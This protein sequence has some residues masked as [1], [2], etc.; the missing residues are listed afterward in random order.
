MNFLLTHYIHPI[1]DEVVISEHL[2]ITLD[3][4][5]TSE[6]IELI[7]TLIAKSYDIDSAWRIPPDSEQDIVTLTWIRKKFHEEFSK[8]DKYVHEFCNLNSNED[9]YTFLAKMWI[10]ARFDDEGQTRI[11]RQEHSKSF[12]KGVASF[13]LLNDEHPIVANAN[14]MV[15]YSYLL[16]LLFHTEGHSY[17]GRSFLINHKISIDHATPDPSICYHITTLSFFCVKGTSHNVGYES[18]WLIFPL[19]KDSLLSVAKHL[20][21]SLKNSEEKLLYVASLLK[22]AGHDIQ[23]DKSKIVSL[24]SILELLLT[25][26]PDFSRYNVEDSINKQFQLK[27]SLLIYLNDRTKN[28]SEIREKLRSIYQLRSNIAHGNFE[29][30]EKLIN[31]LA[32]EKN[33]PAND[34]PR[35]KSEYLE[36]FVHDLYSFIRA[37]LDEF[38]KD[39]IIVEYLKEN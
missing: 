37:V 4:P 35:S 20:D 14:R 39:K 6:E 13:F 26:S 16:A 21:E 33:D 34:S 27:A 19:V 5:R 38:M 17:Y 8:I 11:L 15:N 12:K 36:D 7:R 30:L 22:N 28:L 1:P 9:H 29:Q 24:V 31:R 10:I 25:H 3:N 18:R 23:D 32:K 2:G